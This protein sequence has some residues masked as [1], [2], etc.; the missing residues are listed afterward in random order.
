MGVRVG[1]DEL[2]SQS[3]GRD[4]GST[5]AFIH[6]PQIFYTEIWCLGAEKWL[7]G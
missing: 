7:S 5:S 1:V 2:N 4:Q 3:Y 6:F